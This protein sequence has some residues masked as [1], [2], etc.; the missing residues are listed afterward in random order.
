MKERD[1][2]EFVGSRIKF[3]RK[4]KGLTQAELGKLIRRRNNTVSNYETGTISPEQDA[5]FA[6]ANALNISVNELFPPMSTEDHNATFQKALEMSND[7]DI[8][9]VN[10]LKELIEK[11]LSMEGEDRDKFLESIKFTV[12][13][14]DRMNRD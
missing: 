13:Y 9:D 5:L 10:F 7:L 2:A 12:E 1:L 14:Y 6:I 4:Q 3:F 11:T 8:N